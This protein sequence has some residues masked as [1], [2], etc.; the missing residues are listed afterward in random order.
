[1]DIL[2]ASPLQAYSNEVDLFPSADST[3]EDLLNHIRLTLETLY[4]PVGTCKMGIDEM[5]V[6]DPTL[7]VKNIIVTGKQRDRKSTRLNSSH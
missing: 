6:T 5:A 7:K 2:K 1:M 4:H 3:D